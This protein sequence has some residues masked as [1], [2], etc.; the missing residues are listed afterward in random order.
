M[1]DDLV[2]RDWQGSFMTRHHVRRGIANK[3]HINACCV[4][5][6]CKRKIISGDHGDLFAHGLHL[7]QGRVIVSFHHSLANPTRLMRTRRLPISAR[8]IRTAPLLIQ[9]KDAAGKPVKDARVNATLVQQDFISQEFKAFTPLLIS[10]K[11]KILISITVNT[12]RI[13]ATSSAWLRLIERR[14]WE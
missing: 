14:C 5:D 7:L 13:G 3:D 4:K 8:E 11:W 10:W 6:L 12:K 9:I 2:K 1:I